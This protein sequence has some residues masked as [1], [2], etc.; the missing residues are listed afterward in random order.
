VAGLEQ[1]CP[2]GN[3]DMLNL[4]H[5]SGFLFDLNGVIYQDDRPI[6]GAAET[7]KHLKSKSIPLRFTT[8][9]TTCS[10]GTLRAKLVDMGLPI[11]QEEIFGVTRAAVAFL[12]GKGSPSV[13][14]GLN[15]DTQKDFAEFSRSED[16][17]DYIV[18]GEI[19]SDWSYDLLQ[20]IF[21]LMVDGS[22]LLALHKSRFWHTG[23]RLQMSVG[24]FASA[25]EYATGKQATVVG[26]PSKDFF[27]LG[28]RDM[29]L[30]PEQVAMVGDDIDSDIGGAQRAGMKG[31]LVRTGKY[32]EHLVA[33]STVK[34]DLIVDSAAAIAGL[35]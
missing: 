23:G 21:R 22:S 17:P 11:E 13:L 6:E 5:I 4:T 3:I 34:P 18:I 29:G 1:T 31:I 2:T 8:N 9:T 35:V 19:G 25:L 26:K 10:V 16:K 27:Q 33:Q 20:K 12:R 32:R 24:A 28:V 14:L 15:E 7:I 30:A